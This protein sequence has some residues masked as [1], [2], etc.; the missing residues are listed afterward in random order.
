MKRPAVEEFKRLSVP[1]NGP[2]GMADSDT[3]DLCDWILHLETTLR[4]LVE[5]LAAEDQDGLTEFAP[6]MAA[7]RAVLSSTPK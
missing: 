7:A 4:N 5:G 3:V 6:Q 1:E 2:W